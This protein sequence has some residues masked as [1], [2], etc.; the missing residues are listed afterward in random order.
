MNNVTKSWKV[1]Y[2]TIFF[3]ILSIVLA[4]LSFF[5]SPNQR[6]IVISLTLASILF[7]LLFYYVNKI[8]Y[9]ESSIKIVKEELDK[10]SSSFYKEI[11]YIKDFY[12]LKYNV[13]DFMR[14]K[15]AESGFLLNLI[16]VIVAIILIY[17]IIEV[18]KS[19]F[20]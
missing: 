18:I 5:V 6:I 16:K 1:D 11:N 13:E 14:K 12:E 20:S 19:L 2:W 15:R 3:S 10:F 8:N 4:Q 7:A 17:V 9:N